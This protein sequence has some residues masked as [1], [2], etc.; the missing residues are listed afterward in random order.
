VIVVNETLSQKAL[1]QVKLDGNDCKLVYGPGESNKGAV[2]LWL[3]VRREGS[4]PVVVAAELWATGGGG[5]R[6][7]GWHVSGLLYQPPVRG[8]EPH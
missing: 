5:S 6:E 4:E 2:A 7:D 3:A 8:R 1:G